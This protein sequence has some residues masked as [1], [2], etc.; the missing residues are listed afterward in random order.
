METFFICW[1]GAGNPFLQLTDLKM[2]TNACCLAADLLKGTRSMLIVSG[3]MS[4]KADSAGSCIV[5]R[6]ENSQLWV[7]RP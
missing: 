2:V 6:E 7:Q 5:E 3:K 4:A 1:G